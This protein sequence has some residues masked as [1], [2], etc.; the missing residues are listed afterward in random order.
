MLPLRAEKIVCSI[1]N[2]IAEQNK[3]N[4]RKSTKSTNK[5][6]TTRILQK[7]RN[8]TQKFTRNHAHMNLQTR[9]LDRQAQ[10]EQVRNEPGSE[11]M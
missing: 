7:A 5:S 9:K 8:H 1:S 10:Q 2:G 11:I 3:T 4:H 6:A